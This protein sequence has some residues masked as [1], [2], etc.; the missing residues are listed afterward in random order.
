MP[1]LINNVSA[2]NVELSSQ[3]LDH[4]KQLI[5]ANMSAADQYL[6]DLNFEV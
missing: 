4:I 5:P 1:L 3:D 2:L 6:D